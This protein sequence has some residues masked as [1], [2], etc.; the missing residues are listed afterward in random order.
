MTYSKVIEK[1]AV[2]EMERMTEKEVGT[3]SY[4]IG[5]YWLKFSLLRFVKFRLCIK[6]IKKKKQLVAE[7]GFMNKKLSF[8]CIKV[9]GENYIFERIFETFTLELVIVFYNEKAFFGIID[10]PI[11]HIQLTGKK[12]NEKGWK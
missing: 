2:N 12:V 7:I 1:E 8:K 10:T 6:Q 4:V 5:T 11:G 9:K 3:T